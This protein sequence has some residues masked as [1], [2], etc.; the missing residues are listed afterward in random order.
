MRDGL[1]QVGPPPAGPVEF[2]IDDDTYT[3]PALSTRD[4]LAS[5]VLRP[6]GAWWTLIPGQLPTA[7]ADRLYRRLLDRDD[8]HDL[9]DLE[10]VATTVLRTIAGT[11]WDAACRLAAAACGNWMLFDGWC[12]THGVDPLDQHISRVVAAVYTWR[13][14]MCSKE[15]DL[16]RLDAEVWSPRHLTVTGKPVDPIPPAWDDDREAAAFADMLG[17]FGARGRA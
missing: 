3:L 8:D 16:A 13:R 9:D 6:P 15:S 14:A 4:W 10:T 7:Q 11:D 5:M 17:T 2:A 12:F 1:V